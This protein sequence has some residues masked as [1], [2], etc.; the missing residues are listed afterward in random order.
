MLTMISNGFP[1]TKSQAWAGPAGPETA[2]SILDFY[3]VAAL[4][5]KNRILFI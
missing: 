3:F 4:L 1:F 5:A 2:G